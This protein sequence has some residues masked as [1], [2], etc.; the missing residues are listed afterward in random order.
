MNPRSR[1]A[2]RER[3]EGDC[4]VGEAN[5]SH[6]GQMLVPG[7]G[8]EPARLISTGPSFLRVYQIPPPG[9]FL[10]CILK[11]ILFFSFILPLGMDF[12]R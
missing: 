4:F 1:R 11:D 6:G 8:L 3:Q 9:P 5:R 7:T 10:L 2:C 12:C